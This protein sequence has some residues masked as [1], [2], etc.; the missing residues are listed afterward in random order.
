MIELM[1][2]KYM[3]IVSVASQLGKIASVKNIEPNVYEII[4]GAKINARTPIKMFLL[5]DSSGTIKFSDKKNTLKYMN[6][7]YE[8]KSPDVKNCISSVVK[9]YGFSIVSGELF[10]T[11]RSEDSLRETFFNYI[12]CVGQLANMYAFFD[13]P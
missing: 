1:R 10:A 8:L 13:K 12:I 5:E 2:G 3:D 11:L 9:L 6:Q 4:T 7:L